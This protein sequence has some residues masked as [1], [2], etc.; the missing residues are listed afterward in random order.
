MSKDKHK[1][2]TNQ[3]IQNLWIYIQIFEYVFAS[4]VA[5]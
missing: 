5:I 2:H 3:N 1:L 4:R